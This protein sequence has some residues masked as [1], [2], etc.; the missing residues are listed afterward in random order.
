MIRNL[1]AAAYELAIWVK[2]G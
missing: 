1:P 2:L